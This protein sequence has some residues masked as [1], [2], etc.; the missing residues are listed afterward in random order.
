MTTPLLAIDGVKIALLFRDLDGPDVKI[1][2]R[3]KGDINVHA[4]AMKF[5][6][7]GHF[8]ASGIVMAGDLDQV[9]EQV[10]GEAVRLV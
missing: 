1:S 6:G 3:S 9:M 2:L 10:I 7:G 5:G 8:N 4:L